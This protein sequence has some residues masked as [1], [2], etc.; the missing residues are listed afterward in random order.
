MTTATA[1]TI[2]L[3]PKFSDRLQ[4]LAD[5]SG[6]TPEKMLEHVMRDGFDYTENFV[7]EVKKGIIDADAGKVVSHEAAMSRLQAT[8][9]RHAKKKKAA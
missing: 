9:T 1:T 5:L 3:P 4:K 7:R 6:S 2:T 8:V